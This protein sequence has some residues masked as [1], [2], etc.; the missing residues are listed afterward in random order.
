MTVESAHTISALDESWPLKDDPL[1]QGDDHLRLLKSVLKEQFRGANGQG[2]DTP[3]LASESEL[4][5]L[6]GVTGSVQ[7]QVDNL[8]NVYLPL[9]GGELSGLLKV[10][11]EVRVISNGDGTMNGLSVYD[12]EGNL[13]GALDWF[14]TNGNLQLWQQ[15]TGP[16]GSPDTEIN[17]EGGNVRVT[18]RNGH[19]TDPLSDKDL[20]TK[21]YVDDA[22]AVSS[23]GGIIAH[24]RIS[25]QGSVRSGFRG[26][27]AVQHTGT[28]LYRVYLSM[29]PIYNSK[30]TVALTYEGTNWS[31]MITIPLYG[32]N[33]FDVRIETNDA[34]TDKPFSVVVAV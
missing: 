13:R 14:E 24:G 32:S 5:S 16:Q 12:N 26:I 25:D 8:I 34:L 1:H 17:I 11:E 23:P 18:A 3:I 19:G 15:G 20:T 2:Y 10:S 7:D 31:T 28:G 30:F 9:T 27:G 29:D 33:Y 21:E 6:V 22:I 4:N